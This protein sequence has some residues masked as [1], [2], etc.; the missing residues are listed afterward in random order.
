M[1]NVVE[2]PHPLPIEYQ[3]RSYSADRP[4]FSLANQIFESL[5]NTTDQNEIARYGGHVILADYCPYNQEL[6]YKNSS[7][8]SRCYRANNQPLRRSY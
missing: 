7:R 1:C 3:V 5:S 8:D 2:Y 4:S 6:A